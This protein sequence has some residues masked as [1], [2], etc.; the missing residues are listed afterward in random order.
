MII[1][2]AIERQ[3][4]MK[5]ELS[6]LAKG[7]KGTFIPKKLANIVGIEKTIVIPAKNLIATF[8]LLEII[9]L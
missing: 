7:P 1:E 3:N 9:V 8:K 5:K 6:L 2:I 4:K